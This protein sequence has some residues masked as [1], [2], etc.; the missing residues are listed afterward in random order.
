MLGDLK[1]E[2]RESKVDGWET[3][4][5]I[6]SIPLSPENAQKYVRR[7]KG[8]PQ[9]RKALHPVAT[10]EGE[11]GGGRVRR[12][13]HDFSDKVLNIDGKVKKS[14]KSSGKKVG[15]GQQNGRK[16]KSTGGSLE[17]DYLKPE[18]SSKKSVRFGKILAHVHEI[19][20]E[21]TIESITETRERDAR[22]YLPV[23]EVEPDE[24]N[25]DEDGLV[26][27]N[28]RERNADQHDLGVEG[29]GTQGENGN[30][31]KGEHSGA[32]RKE[33]NEN[34][35][36]PKQT[37]GNAAE[38]NERTKT[39]ETDEEGRDTGEFLKESTRHE[40]LKLSQIPEIV[41][42]DTTESSKESEQNGE[43]ILKKSSM[44]SPSYTYLPP[45]PKSSRGFV[46]KKSV[47]VN[48]ANNSLPRRL[49]SK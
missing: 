13:S 17:V 23:I 33:S 26:G 41:V 31:T 1:L 3:M 19:S 44:K 38:N 34:T 12:S 24:D 48:K 21:P 7:V 18:R 5:D 30:E 37:N 20:R 6:Y 46:G 35:N 8:Q 49:R 43:K 29:P 40:E 42:T 14:A 36:N 4:E 27:E 45:R 15:F 39:S 22:E 28:G 11:L 47:K 16:Q 2:L 9:T 32:G 10:F 25:L